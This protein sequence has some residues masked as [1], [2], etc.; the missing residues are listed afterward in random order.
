MTLGPGRRPKS[1]SLSHTTLN[2]NYQVLSLKAAYDS[3]LCV[4]LY[5][6]VA[7]KIRFP[8]ISWNIRLSG[9]S[10]DL[11]KKDCIDL[12]FYLSGKLAV[13]EVDI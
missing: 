8:I 9:Q 1:L 11:K 12:Y 7:L 10:S 13:S 3:T 5:L 4:Y 6:Y 2:I